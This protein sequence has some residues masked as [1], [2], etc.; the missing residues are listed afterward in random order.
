MEAMLSTG[1]RIGEAIALIGPNVD[2]AAP[3]LEVTHHV[4]RVIGEGLVRRDQRKGDAEGLLLALPRWSVPM[5]QRRKDTAG[6]G[7]LFASFAGDLLDPSNVINR[8]AKAM[9]AVGYG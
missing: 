8:I 7:P 1:I 9:E 6:D 2:P 3:T 4:I 5:W